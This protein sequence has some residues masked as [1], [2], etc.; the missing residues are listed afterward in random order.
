MIGLRAFVDRWVSA[1]LHQFAV[2]HGIE[3]PD[4]DN[5]DQYIDK[6][7]EAADVGHPAD[8]HNDGGPRP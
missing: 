2:E 3:L 4:R 8:Y 6:A 7:C 5:L 1:Q